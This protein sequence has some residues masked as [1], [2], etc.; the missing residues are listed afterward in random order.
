MQ[1]VSAPEG[2]DQALSNLYD[3]NQYQLSDEDDY[4]S[5]HCSPQNSAQV[6]VDIQQVNQ[7]EYS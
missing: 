1:G 2:E 5:W 4:Q 7:A 6:P 3:S